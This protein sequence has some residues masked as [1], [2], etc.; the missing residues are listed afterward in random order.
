MSYHHLTASEREVIAPMRY[1]GRNLCEIARE[2]GRY[3]GT[4]SREV[5]RNGS[6]CR[7][8]YSCLRT[9]ILARQ[10]RREAKLHVPKKINA[11]HLLR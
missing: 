2:L 11:P 4:I 1:A 3:P 8:G 7:L 6:R 10:P 5:R 9:T